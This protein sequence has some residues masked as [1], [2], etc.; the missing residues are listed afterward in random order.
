MAS[1]PDSTQVPLSEDEND[2]D[3]FGPADTAGAGGTGQPQQPLRKLCRLHR[4]GC[5][6][7]L[8]CL[9]IC[10]EL[11]LM[12]TF[13]RTGMLNYITRCHMT[14]CDAGSATVPQPCK[15]QESRTAVANCPL[16]ACPPTAKFKVAYGLCPLG[17]CM[18]EVLSSQLGYCNMVNAC[19]PH[20]NT[21]QL[22]NVPSRE[23]LI[24]RKP[25]AI[26]GTGAEFTHSVN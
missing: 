12:L 15:L 13:L 18:G 9:Q 1:G 22:G 17:L 23:L 21:P 11:G 16:T 5:L 7:M 6:L 10:T 3:L 25:R 14:R 24:E 26:H 2:F 19:Q 8:V 20:Y 4:I